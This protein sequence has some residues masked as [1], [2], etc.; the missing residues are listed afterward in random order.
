[1]GESKP[2]KRS[3]A[4]IEFSRDHHFGLLLAWKIRKGLKIE[5]NPERISDY[6]LHFYEND[7]ALHFREEEE[8]LFVQLSSD[9]PLRV[10]AEN[11]HAQVYKYIESLRRQPVD[12]SSLPLL[13]DLLESHIRFEERELFPQLERALGEERLLELTIHSAPRQRDLD[14]TWNDPFWEVRNQDKD[15]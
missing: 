2:L 4:L 9:D 12:K 10:R 11:D 14:E 13:A 15:K 1:M 7:L 3:K 8:F 5:I 6:V